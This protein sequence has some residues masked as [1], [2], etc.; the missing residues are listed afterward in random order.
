MLQQAKEHVIAPVIEDIATDDRR[1]SR[2][3]GLHGE[4]DNRIWQGSDECKTTG[5]DERDSTNKCIR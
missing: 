2:C 1:I 4:D 3:L 5:G